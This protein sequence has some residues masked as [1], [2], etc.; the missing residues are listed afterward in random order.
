MM[1]RKRFPV[2]MVPV[3][4][5]GSVISV[6]FTAEPLTP[7]EQ[8]RYADLDGRPLQT[9]TN[10]DLADYLAL[11][12]KDLAAKGEAPDAAGEVACCA[13]KALGQAF[14]L[15]ASRFDYA[16][17][18]CVVAV[19]RALAM[20]LS[21]DWDSYYKLCERL[22]YKEGRVDFLER[23]FMTLTQWV[24]NNA[25]LLCDITSELGPVNTFQHVAAPKRFYTRLSFGEREDSD[26][27]RAKAAAKAAKVATVPDRVTT[28][29]TYI[30]RGNVPDVLDKLQTGDVALVMRVFKSSTGEPLLDCDH[31]GVIVRRDDGIV[32]FTHAAPPCVRQQPL[33]E[34][35]DRFPSVRG[36]KFLRPRAGALALVGDMLA[37]AGSVHVPSP[38]EEDANVARVRNARLNPSAGR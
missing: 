32:N 14:R 10:V 3:L 34:F 29:E 9:F 30:E 28:T 4:I 20:A 22:R 19:E 37:Q 8:G 36:L 35:L 6:A 17:S 1:A 25:W 12:H 23:N 33:T 31:M 24:P 18:D 2:A 7:Q 27:G 13:N 38:S 16:E 26:K 21:T 15:G 11:R 5:V